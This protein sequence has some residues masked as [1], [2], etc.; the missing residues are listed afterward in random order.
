M[1]SNTN[2]RKLLSLKNQIVLAVIISF[3]NLSCYSYT[4][5]SI[6]SINKKIPDHYIKFEKKDKTEELAKIKT[7]NMKDSL[8]VVNQGASE[9]QFTFSELNK[10]YDKEF[11]WF[12]SVMLIPGIAL[13]LIALGILYII[14]IGQP[15]NLVG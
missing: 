10:V 12:N 6:E 4:E 9:K 14:F 3:I 13:G 5:I 11:S 2:L 8:I 1:V 15:I 7:I